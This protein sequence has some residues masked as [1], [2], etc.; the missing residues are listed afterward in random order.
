MSD[1][2]LVE[3]LPDNDVA[4]F[5][6]L[7]ILTTYLFPRDYKKVVDHFLFVLVEDFNEMNSF[8]WDMLLFQIT[9]G[10]LRDGLSRRT[11]HYRLRGMIVAFQA[12]I[13]ETFP[14]LEGIV[15]TRISRVHLRIVN[16]MADKQPSTAKLEGPDCFSNPKIVI[17]DLEPLESEMAMPYMNGVQYNKR[18]QPTSST[19]SQRRTK[20]K[21]ESNIG[22]AHSLDDDDDFIAPPPRRQ[23]PSARGKSPVVEGLIVTHHSQEEPQSHGVQRDNAFEVLRLQGSELQA[24][25][26]VLK[27]ELEEIKSHMSSLNEGKTNKMDDIIQMQACTQSDLMDIRTNMRFLSE[28]V[29]T[30][31]SS[32]MDEIIRRSGDRTSEHGVGQKEALGV[33]D[34]EHH[35]AGG[36]EKAQEKMEMDPSDDLLFSLEPPSFDL[37]IEFT[38]PNVLHSKET[39]KRVDFIISDVVIATKTVE[40]EGSPTAE[41]T[42]ELPVKRVLRPSRVLQSPFV[43]EQEREKLFKRDDNVVIFEDYE[44]NV[45]EVLQGIELYV[46]VLLA[47]MNTLGISKKDPDYHA[48]EAKELKVIIDDTLPQQTNGH[49]CEIF[50]VLYA[51]YLIRGGRCSILQKFDASKFRMDI[52]TLLYKHR[53]FYT[54]KVNQPTT[55]EAVVIE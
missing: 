52:A 42:S 20:R 45:D 51:L 23:E 55:G 35:G 54:K 40:N 12:W 38:L 36:S 16:W 15:V 50:V 1:L 26:E 34:Q 3:A 33:G 5:G 29:S 39:Q 46:K 22:Q 14:S 37:G 30:M 8:P 47:L 2:D 17:C 18:I 4:M 44:D 6:A 10:A 27:M 48:P 41:P 43:V 32:T 28:S 7:Y 53:Q 25:N 21:T 24:D 19:E 9:L 11:P 49:D 31:I 13:Y